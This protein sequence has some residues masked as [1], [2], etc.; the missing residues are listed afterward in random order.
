MR[1]HSTFDRFI[2]SLKPIL[3]GPAALA[4]VPAL[5]LGAFWLGGERALVSMALGLPLAVA[6]IGAFSNTRSSPRR[7]SATG[8][9][10]N[11]HFASALTEV[12]AE[13]R[14][15]GEDSACFAVVLDDYTAL[16]DLHG[17]AAANHVA[18][19]FYARVMSMIRTSDCATQIGENKMMV[20]LRPERQLDLETCIQMSGR[21]QSAIEE[22]IMLN[23]T[24]VYMSCSIGFCLSSSFPE[25][26]AIDWRDAAN[27]ALL[28]AQQNGPSTIRAFSSATRRRAL[29]RTNLRKEFETALDNGEIRPWFQPQISTDTGRVTGFEALARWEHPQKGILGPNVFLPFAEHA[30]LMGRLGQ[31]VRHYAFSAMRNWDQSSFHVPRIGVNFSSD[32]LRDPGLIDR[33]KWELDQFDLTPDRLA[34]EVLETVF[35]R[36]PD[37]VITRNVTGL[38]AMGYC[39][40]LDDFGT[41]HASIASIKRFHVSRIKIDRSFVTKADQDPSQQQLASAILTMAERL[42]LETLAEGVETPG[43]HALMAQLGCDH[44]QGFGIGKPMPFEKTKDWITSYRSKLDGVPKIGRETG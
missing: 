13:T 6:G 8:L 40:D 17:Q 43:E 7:R 42:N 34:V 19:Q 44:V 20:V 11:D 28:E 21:M 31:T 33:L 27:N 18:Q 4:F 3:N 1:N 37:D 12:F 39:I 32:E 15:T 16:L 14:R 38:A 25:G 41:G 22:P 26:S 2:Q 29:V 10:S 9:L 23:G 30:D 36:R 35:S 24:G 5:S